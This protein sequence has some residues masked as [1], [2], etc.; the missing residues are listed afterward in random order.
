MISTS[1][2]ALFSPDLP[3]AEING[4][5]NENTKNAVSDGVKPWRPREREKSASISKTGLYSAAEM[6][7]R[8]QGVTASVRAFKKRFESLRNSDSLINSLLR[9]SAES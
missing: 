5:L 8:L 1:S 4:G 6:S 3:S 2:E 7:L 9:F